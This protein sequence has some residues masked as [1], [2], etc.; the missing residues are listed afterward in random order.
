M[1]VVGNHA[2]NH[3]ESFQVMRSVKFGIQNILK[4]IAAGIPNLR[5]NLEQL[6]FQD[7]L[8]S[9]VLIR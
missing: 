7:Y 9:L 3:F 4:V 6:V 8:N 1:K 2:S 5:S